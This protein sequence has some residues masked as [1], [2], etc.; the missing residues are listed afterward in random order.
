MSFSAS[1]G[2]VPNSAPVMPAVAGRAMSRSDDPRA[3]RSREKLI[4][5]FCR[6]AET[7]SPG[8]ITVAALTESAGVHRSVF[9][10]HFASPDELAIHMLRDLFGALSRTDVVLRSEI[11]V[12]GLQASRSAMTEFV[13]FVGARRS[14]YAPLLGSR[15]PAGAVR[16]VTDAFAELTAEAI[17]QM[18]VRPPDVD[19][20]FVSRFLAHGVVGVTGRWLDDADSPA[21]E[22]Q[23][24]EQLLACFPAWLIADSTSDDDSSHTDEEGR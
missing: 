12:G 14:W 9:Y 2:G 1:F 18:A 13:R 7:A 4:D 21:S 23:I 15:A 24:V 16:C 17:G 3:V 5:A 22:G 6:L 19:P 8:E 20:H 10:R 11:A